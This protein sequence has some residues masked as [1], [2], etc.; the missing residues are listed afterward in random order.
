MYSCITSSSNKQL[1]PIYVALDGHHCQYAR[2]VKL[3]PA[4]STDNALGQALLA[5]ALIKSGNPTQGLSTLQ[6]ILWFD[7]SELN[8][9]L[10]RRQKRCRSAASNTCTPSSAPTTVLDTKKGKKSKKKDTVQHQEALEPAVDF[11]DMLEMPLVFEDGWDQ[12]LT[13]HPSKT[14][15]TDEVRDDPLLVALSNTVCSLFWYDVL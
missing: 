7:S 9:E 3:A 14:V 5:H 15:I 11:I 10:R 2:A 13:I 6:S 8:H 4:L 1:H 12:L